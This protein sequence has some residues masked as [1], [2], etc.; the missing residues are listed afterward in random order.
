MPPTDALDPTGAPAAGPTPAA[1]PRLCPSA[2]A[3][4]A[5][6][7]V[8]AVVGGTAERPLAAYLEQ[9]QPMTP[10]LAALTGPVDP[11]AVFRTAAPCAQGGCGHFDDAHHQCRL[12]QKTV[13]LAPVV[14]HKLPRCAVRSDCVW[15][16][17][18]GAAACRRCPQ[19]VTLDTAPSAAM[20]YAA[21]HG[22]R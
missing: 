11:S 19:V 10:A 16:H 6:A 9:A 2:G 17:Q 14:V 12:A 7:Q 3:H 13:R 20:A 5:G 21:D 22:T 18:E 8:F 4:A 1:A 15:W